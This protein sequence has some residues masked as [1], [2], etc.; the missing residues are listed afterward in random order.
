MRAWLPARVST[1]T[2][3][4]KPRIGRSA[5]LRGIAPGSV[6]RRAPRPDTRLA[7]GSFVEV[8]RYR[9]ISALAEKYVHHVPVLV[10]RPVQIRP[11]CVQVAV[12]L[13]RSPLCTTGRLWSQAAS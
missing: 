7:Y 13:V 5:C 4:L 3:H 11:P 1:E 6:G 2:G 9:C 12:R 8:G 10:D